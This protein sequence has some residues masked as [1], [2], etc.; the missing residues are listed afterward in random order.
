[1]AYAV[2]ITKAAE[3]DIRDAYLLHRT[4]QRVRTCL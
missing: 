2:E 1:M 3:E 4:K